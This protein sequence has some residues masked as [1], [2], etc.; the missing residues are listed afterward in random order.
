MSPD[1]RSVRSLAAGTHGT[2]TDDAAYRER[3]AAAAMRGGDPEWVTPV[4]PRW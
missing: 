2:A 1:G 4:I 3:D